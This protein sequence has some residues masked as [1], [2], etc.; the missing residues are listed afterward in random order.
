[1]RNLLELD[2]SCLSVIKVQVKVSLCEDHDQIIEPGQ[3]FCLTTIQ[4]SPPALLFVIQRFQICFTFALLCCWQSSSG[5]RRC[6]C[7]GRGLCHPCGIFLHEDKKFIVMKKTPNMLIKKVPRVPRVWHI[8]I[9][10]RERL[11]NTLKITRNM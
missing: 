8:V 3:R 5:S 6:G 10:W 4:E 2:R 9:F 1:M 11:K 7:R